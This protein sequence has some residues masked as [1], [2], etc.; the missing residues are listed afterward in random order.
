MG[1]AT[2]ET[3]EAHTAPSI[4]A[5]SSRRGGGCTSQSALRLPAPARPHIADATGAPFPAGALATLTSL[6][7]FQG[8]PSTSAPCSRFLPEGAWGSLVHLSRGGSIW[9]ARGRAG[10]TNCDEG[11]HSLTRGAVGDGLDWML[12]SGGL[13]LQLR[14][15]RW[16]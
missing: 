9:E 1:P 4:I 3:R 8:S 2:A 5:S 14:W 10:G 11:G 7:F 15:G 16:W 13:H 12:M 6:L